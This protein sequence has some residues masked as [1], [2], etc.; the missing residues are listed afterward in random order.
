MCPTSQD[1]M[2]IPV[3][4]AERPLNKHDT[5]GLMGNHFSTKSSEREHLWNIGAVVAPEP[6]VST[7]P[8]STR[9]ITPQVIHWLLLSFVCAEYSVLHQL[10]EYYL[11]TYCFFSL[12]SIFESY[13]PRQSKSEYQEL[14]M[15]TASVLSTLFF[16]TLALASPPP[17]RVE[18]KRDQCVPQ[19]GTQESPGCQSPYVLTNTPHYSTGCRDTS[20]CQP[21]STTLECC[22]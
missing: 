5:V 1:L 2:S 10:S 21:E 3:E 18:V 12:V 11:I 4:G 22:V 19:I 7:R 9:H 16:A 8:L 13:T 15:K 14:A 17:T 6:Y 20:Q